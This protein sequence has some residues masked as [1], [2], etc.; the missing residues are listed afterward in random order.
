[1]LHFDFPITEKNAKIFIDI[2]STQITYLL[3]HP[4]ELIV[5]NVVALNKN[6]NI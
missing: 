5:C 2:V 1:M 6:L 4:D 3:T